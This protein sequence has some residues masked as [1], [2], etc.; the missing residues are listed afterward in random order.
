MARPKKQKPIEEI[1]LDRIKYLV[2]DA[3]AEMNAPRTECDYGGH[4][5]AYQ[6]GYVRN[7]LEQLIKELGL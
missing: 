4:D 6:A 7:T 2:V 5:Y 3:F 1:N